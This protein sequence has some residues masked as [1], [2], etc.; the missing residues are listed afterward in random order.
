MTQE[1][2]R[3]QLWRLFPKQLDAYKAVEGHRFT[4]LIGQGR[5][6]KTMFAVWYCFMRGMAHPKTNHVIFRHTLA[7]AVDG[8]WHTTVMEAIQHFFP[9]LPAMPGFQINQTTKT[10]VLP[11]GSRIMIR[12]LDTPQRANKVLS[13]QY[14]TVV[15]DEGQTFPYSYFALLLTRLP[16]PVDVSYKVKFVVTANYAPKTHWTKSFFLDGKNPETGAV[17]GEDAVILHF[18][19]DDN[20][21]IDADSYIRTLQAAG[22]RRARLMCAGTDW[23]SVTEGALWKQEDIQQRPKPEW[24]DE[25]ILSYD[26]AVTANENSD[27]HGVSIIGRLG[28][29][30][31]VLECF[32]EV[33]DINEMTDKV[34]SLFHAYDCDSLVYEKNQGGDFIEALI[35]AH[36]SRIY[37]RPVV[38]SKGK[39][40]RAEPVAALYIAGRVFHCK[41][42]TQVED[43]MV[44]YAGGGKSPNAL[45][46][47]VHGIRYLVDAEGVFV[48][49]ASI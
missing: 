18:T 9:V 49:P 13:Q 3:R 46:A 47:L 36:D 34:C 48:D 17:H 2:A 6:S 15:T 35:R 29:K 21:A 16:Q 37:C 32:E 11:N 25:L 31:Y 30:C 1:D 42:M 41:A 22:D 40:L 5:A 23:Y 12:G 20:K 10:V 26:P 8:I 45:D 38:A 33:R 27:G 4:L 39:M 24:F 19:T 7:A 28:E 44:S 43:Q 14:A